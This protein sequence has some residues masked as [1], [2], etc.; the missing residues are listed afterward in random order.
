[1]GLILTAVREV[2]LSLWP[3]YSRAAGG[4]AT[5]AALRLSGSEGFVQQPALLPGRGLARTQ[6]WPLR[7]YLALPALPVSVRSARLHARSLLPEWRMDGLADIAELL[8]SEMITNAVRASAPLADRQPEPGQAPRARRMRLWLTSD[9]HSLLIQVWDAD[10]HQP[11]RR[12]VGPDAEA[13]RGLLLIE[14]LSQQWGCYVPDGQD[15][16]IVWAL[17][18]R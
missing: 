8:V 17:C 14:A 2:S 13:G 10:E 15:G 3:Y 4:V 11:V 18:A 5:A 12:D 1:M 7:S 9:R 16:K 6:E